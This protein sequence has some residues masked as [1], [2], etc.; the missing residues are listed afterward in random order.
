CIVGLWFVL[1]VFAASF[2]LPL[3]DLF[4]SELIVFSFG[5]EFVCDSCSAFLSS[6]ILLQLHS[7]L[8]DQRIC[9]FKAIH[10]HFISS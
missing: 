2:R 3:C 6:W 10:H 7:L 9:F 1:I 4:R 5:S 8:V